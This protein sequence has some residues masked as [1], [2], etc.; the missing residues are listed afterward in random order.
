MLRRMKQLALPY[1][2][3][4]AASETFA[5]ERSVIIRC[6]AFSGELRIFSTEPCCVREAHA[7]IDESSAHVPRDILQKKCCGR[8]MGTSHGR[9]NLTSAKDAPKLRTK[10]MRMVSASFIAT[11]FC[12]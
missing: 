11:S 6:G 10:I 2:A 3:H 1:V 4:R 7:L 5:Q 8:Y 9:P 12:A